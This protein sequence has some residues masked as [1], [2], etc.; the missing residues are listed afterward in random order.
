MKPFICIPAKVVA[1]VE[2]RLASNVIGFM[3]P[4]R[5]CSFSND[6]NKEAVINVA[7]SHS[8]MH[9]LLP[10]LSLLL[11]VSLSYWSGYRPPS[12][13]LAGQRAAQKHKKIFSKYILSSVIS[14]EKLDLLFAYLQPSGVQ[15][16]TWSSIKE[17]RGDMTKV[18][19][20]DL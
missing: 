4:I 9:F 3:D 1:K 12:A 11:A 6:I 16:F 10:F 5:G 19:H 7:Q 20:L 15:V 18:M 2:V 17:T 14:L 8:L 13:W